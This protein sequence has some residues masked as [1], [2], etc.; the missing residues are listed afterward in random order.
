MDT[1]ADLNVYKDALGATAT[2]SDGD[3]ARHT[4]S[5]LGCCPPASSELDEKSCRKP[6]SASRASRAALCCAASPPPP[7]PRATTTAT[8]T[9]TTLGKDVYDTLADEDLNEWVGEWSSAHL[10]SSLFPRAGC[11]IVSCPVFVDRSPL[12]PSFV[13]LSLRST[14]SSSLCCNIHVPSTTRRSP[15]PSPPSKIPSSLPLCPARADHK[16]HTTCA[17]SLV[18]DLR[19]QTWCGHVAGSV[20]WLCL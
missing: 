18:Q 3:E 12:R 17:L 14:L 16:I 15:L 8:T 11:V 2:R 5:R 1:G 6:A 19:R 20:V 9:M 4:G 10:E 7:P 13:P